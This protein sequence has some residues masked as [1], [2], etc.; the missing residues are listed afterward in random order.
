MISYPHIAQ[1]T[2]AKKVRNE[3]LQEQSQ[4]GEPSHFNKTFDPLFNIHGIRLE[5]GDELSRDL[6]NEVVVDHMLPILHDPD[7][8][9]LQTTCQILHTTRYEHFTS[10]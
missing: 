3:H 10:V 9:C 8:T 6:V 7:D 5:P 1:D 2:L 4:R